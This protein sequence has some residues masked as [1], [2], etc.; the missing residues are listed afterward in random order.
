M[1]KV[2][3]PVPW[4]GGKS[5]LAEWILQYLPPHRIYVEVFGGSA[6]VLFAKDPAPVEVY[7]DL[8]DGLV[9]FYRV[10]QDPQHFEALTRRVSLTPYSRVLWYEYRQTWATVTDPVE[11]AARWFYVA[12][13][14]FSGHFGNAW[15]FSTAGI[16][17][18]KQVS[19]WLAAI[20]GLPA[21]HQR[22]RRVIVEQHDWAT[23]MAA[24]DRPETCFY[25][26]PPYVPDTRRSGTYT[27]ELSEDDH[28][29]LV[30][31]LLRT[32]GMVVLSGYAHPLYAPLE[33]AGWCRVD[34]PVP[35]RP[36]TGET[37][38]GS[39]ASNASG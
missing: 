3:T 24:Y 4:F 9:H 28:A 6:A 12:R 39:V 11:R 8:D 15:S 5:Q 2:V 26:D 14:S 7:N 29:R 32:Q 16:G 25:C 19:S 30:D 36:I 22:M 21:W 1:A 33:Q 37:R 38:R 27:H 31:T 17:L 18:N 35:L 13:A 20:E 23:V 10:L 34:R